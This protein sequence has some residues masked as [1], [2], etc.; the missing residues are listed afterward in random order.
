MSPSKGSTFLNQTIGLPNCDGKKQADVGPELQSSLVRW[1]GD[2]RHLMW[3][4]SSF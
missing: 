4:V 1:A 2:L 3:P